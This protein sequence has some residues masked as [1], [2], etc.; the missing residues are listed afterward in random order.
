MKEMIVHC[1][2]Y[3]DDA[4]AAVFGHELCSPLLKG[5]NYMGDDI[6]EYCRGY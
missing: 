3:L 5:V 6:R 2:A 1:A 4:E